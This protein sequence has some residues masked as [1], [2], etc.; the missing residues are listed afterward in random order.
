MEKWSQLA[1]EEIIKKTVAALQKNGIDSMVAADGKEAKKK[2]LALL[3]EGAQVMT[4][5]S[6]TLD[7]IGL[8]GEINDLGKYDSVRKKLMVLDVKTQWSERQKL[9][10]APDWAVGSVQAVTEEGQVLIASN[11]GSQLPAYASGSSH[12]IWVVGTQKIV[13]DLDEGFKRVYEYSLP[14]E[15]ARAQ[16]A[17]GVHSHVSKIL[18][19]NKENSLGRITLIF[20][21][22]KLGF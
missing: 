4:M 14:R 6:V 21:K 16:K 10:A 22:E 15:D 12:V 2:V 20:V 3:P 8:A 9:G 1:R 19:I 18:I 5:S 17:Y 13:Q 11:S 7:T